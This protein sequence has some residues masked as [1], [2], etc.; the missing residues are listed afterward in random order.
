[1]QIKSSCSD[2]DSCM[3]LSVSYCTTLN[4]WLVSLG[5]SNCHL[6]KSTLQRCALPFIYNFSFRST[7]S[8]FNCHLNKLL[9]ISSSIS[10]SH[11]KDAPFHSVTISHFDQQAVPLFNEARVVPMKFSYFTIIPNLMYDINHWV[12]FKNSFQYPF[13]HYLIVYV[14]QFLYSKLQTLNPAK[15]ALPNWINYME[16]NPFGTK[17]A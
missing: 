16:S 1:M 14:K 12:G 8:T 4:L 13:L 2:T 6:N 7:S 17:K 5:S 3:H 15:L 11:C 10:S 9:T